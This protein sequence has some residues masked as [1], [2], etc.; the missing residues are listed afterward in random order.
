VIF[1]LIFSA[2]GYVGLGLFCAL[3]A[4]L[5]VAWILYRTPAHG[6]APVILAILAVPSL[7]HRLTPRAD[8]F[9]T[10]LFALVLA[11]LWQPAWPH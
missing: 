1:Y 8:L 3:V 10:V 6:L 5:L 2:T 7:Q 11:E 9:T 4:A